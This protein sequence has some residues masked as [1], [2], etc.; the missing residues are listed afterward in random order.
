VVKKQYETRG[1]KV[2]KKSREYYQNNKE[3]I[4]PKRQAYQ[5]KSMQDPHFRLARRLRNRLYHALRETVW[6]KNT[7]FAEYIGCDLPTLKAHIEAQFT[8]TMSWD[9]LLEGRIHIDHKIPLVSASTEE[10]LYKLCHFLNLQPLWALDNIRKGDS[11]FDDSNEYG[12]L[13]TVTSEESSD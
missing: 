11:I 12:I 10:E 2:K 9:A 4:R 5:K 6:K 3:A 8:D 7:H 1:E 13:E